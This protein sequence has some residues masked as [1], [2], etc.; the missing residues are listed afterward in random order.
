VA[1]LF[2]NVRHNNNASLPDVIHRNQRFHPIDHP[3]GTGAIRC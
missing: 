1:H 2:L 3:T